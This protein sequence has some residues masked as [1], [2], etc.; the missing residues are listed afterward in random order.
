MVLLDR[1]FSKKRCWKKHGVV[2]FMGGVME[3]IVKVMS[4]GAW[5]GGVVSIYLVLRRDRISFVSCKPVL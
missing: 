5:G 4:A 3:V 1:D 2:F